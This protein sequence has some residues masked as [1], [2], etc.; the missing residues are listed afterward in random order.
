MANEQAVR[1]FIEWQPNARTRQLY[2]HI[3]G[4]VESYPER[5]L[6]ALTSR[7]VYYEL[8]GRY[9]SEHGYEKGTELERRAYRL[10]S[11]MRRARHIPF[12]SINDNSFD[13]LTVRSYEDPEELYDEL[14][15]F[16]DTYQKDLLQ[17]QPAYVRVQCEGAGKVRQ[18][19]R[20]ARAYCVPVYSPGGWDSLA[21]KYQTARKIL[22]EWRWNLRKS[23][24]LHAGDLDPDGA[25]IFEAWKEDVLEFVADDLADGFDPEEVVSFKRIMTLPEQVPAHGRVPFDASKVKEK[26]YRGQSWD[27]PFTA[28]IE[29]IPLERRLEIL[30][31]ELEEVLDLDRL[32]L[33]REANERERE[34][35]RRELESLGNL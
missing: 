16:R 5:G 11:L 18:F 34:E 33:D 12:D 17:N 20:V 28:E 22:Y 3:K 10:I 24:I 25:G 23:V 2:E 14:R 30:R 1:G 27:L 35:I 19:H 7:D 21:F 4:I 9:G 15:K 13:S 26:N 8:L 31:A 29:A 32:S 6:P